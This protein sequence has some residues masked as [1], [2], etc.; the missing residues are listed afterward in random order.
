MERGPCDFVIDL[1]PLVETHRHHKAATILAI[2][3]ALT[4]P[5]DRCPIV[6]GGYPS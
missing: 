6:L 5:I 2:D 3:G 1:L 4:L